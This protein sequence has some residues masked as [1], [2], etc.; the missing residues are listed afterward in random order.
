MVPDLASYV[1][2]HYTVIRD[3]SDPRGYTTFNN[4]LIRASSHV[5]FNTQKVEYDVSRDD[6]MNVGLN[7]VQTIAPGSVRT[8]RFYAGDLEL[9][10][11]AA[12]GDGKSGAYGALTG[13]SFPLVATPMEY[14]AMPIF[15]ADT[16]K[17]G[18]KGL[19][20]VMTILPAGSTFALDAGTTAQATVTIPGGRVFRDFSMV[21]QKSVNMRYRD[22]TPVEHISG[23]G[24]GVPEDAHDAGGAAI[25]FAAEPLWFRFGFPAGA[26]WG[27]GDTGGGAP[28]PA[29]PGP[30]GPEPGVLEAPT[31]PGLAS[32]TDAFR[33]YSNIMTGGLDPETPV[34]KARPGQE[35]RFRIAI[36]AGYARNTTLTIFGHNWREEPFRSVNA[37]S[38]VM[39][40]HPSQIFRSTTDNIVTG[41]SWNILT[42]AGGAMAVPGDYLYRDVASFGHLNGLWGVVRVEEPATTP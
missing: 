13:N 12:S 32:I 17:Q 19:L 35:M 8:Y 21:F 38:D 20:G 2:Q 4:N 15:P 37:P 41:N 10:P 18:Q 23:E 27:Y 24:P 7:P 3:R 31:G 33:A 16:I 11:R 6:G 5:G 39:A 34:Y 25:N 14:G 26:D 30:F 22:G 29:D 28:A 40:V 1:T 36:P 42:K 9:G